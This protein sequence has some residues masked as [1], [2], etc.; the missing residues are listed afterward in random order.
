MRIFFTVEPCVAAEIT[1]VVKSKLFCLFVLF[2]IQLPYQKYCANPVK[3]QI[4]FSHFWN[5]EDS[6]LV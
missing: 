1:Y 4:N 5:Y 3:T 6:S 2:R